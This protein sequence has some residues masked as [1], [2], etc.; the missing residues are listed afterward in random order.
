M[1]EGASGLVIFP[2]ATGLSARH[3]RYYLAPGAGHYG[4][5]N[6]AKWRDTIAPIV[7]E[8]IALHGR[9]QLRAAA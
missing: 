5:F 4:I 6:G 1:G 9:G 2:L 8:W 3:K 7:E